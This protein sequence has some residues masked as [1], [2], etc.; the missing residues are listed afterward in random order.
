MRLRLDDLLHTVKVVV[1]AFHD[2]LLIALNVKVHYLEFRWEARLDPIGDVLEI[3]DKLLTY[4]KHSLQ[5][6]LIYTIECYTFECL[7]DAI[8]DSFAHPITTKLQ[9]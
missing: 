2:H 1:Y 8:L 4:L 6:L 5:L 7:H 3:G 9:R